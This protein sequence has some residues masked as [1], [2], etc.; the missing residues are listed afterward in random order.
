MVSVLIDRPRMKRQTK[1]IIGVCAAILVAIALEATRSHYKKPWEPASWHFAFSE[2][3]AYQL[4]WDDKYSFDSIVQGEQLNDTRRPRD[5]MALTDVQIESLRRAILNR[6]EDGVIGMC[7]YPH[8]AFVFFGSDNQVVGHYDVCF[9]CSNAGGAP[10]GFSGFP[11]YDALRSLF[12]DL[13]MPI[14]NPEWRD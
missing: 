6:K 14:A 5:G 1:V 13:G 7:R 12:T 8:H 3:R 10:G 11:D 4:N 2:V 9:L